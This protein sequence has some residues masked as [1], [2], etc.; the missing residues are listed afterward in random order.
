MGGDDGNDV[1]VFLPDPSVTSPPWRI[2]S[3]ALH[4]YGED[5][6][7]LTFDGEHRLYVLCKPLTRTEPLGRVLVFASGATGDAE[8]IRTLT[9]PRGS[10]PDT[11]LMGIA[12]DDHNR[13]LLLKGEFAEVDGGTSC[14]SG[15]AVS[16]MPSGADGVATPASEIAGDRT[17]LFCPI[18]IAVDS[19]GRIYVSDEGVFVTVYDPGDTGDAVPK[20][21]INPHRNLITMTADRSGN[22]IVADWDSHSVL[23]Y[24]R[25]SDSTADRELSGSATGIGLPNAL[26]ADDAGRIYVASTGKPDSDEAP[27]VSVF[28]PMASGDVSPER[29]LTENVYGEAVA[30]A[31]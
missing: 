24:G 15:G 22:V 16:I 19:V 26:A 29:T 7:S 18:D 11:L 25:G 23:E 31:P 30:V 5:C 8:P 12:V 4:R 17:S 10:S 2:T 1:V 27:G 14:G 9:V 13:L 21:I 6:D 28:A 20:R 3:A